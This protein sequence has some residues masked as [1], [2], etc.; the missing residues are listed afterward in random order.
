L[1]TLG[2]DAKLP[3]RGLTSENIQARCRGVLL[4]ALSNQSGVLLL[5]CTNKSE[6]AMGYGTLY[7]DLTGGFAVLK[8]VSKTRV[9]E[10]ANFRNVDDVFPYELLTRSPTAELAENQKDEDILPP[11]SQLDPILE[12]YVEQHKSI[13]DIV[14]AGFSKEIV[15]RIVSSVDKNEFKRRQLAPGPKITPHAFNRER[16][17]PITS[18]FLLP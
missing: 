10:L 18:G 8:D 14:K 13:D 4:M 9:Y 17:F 1:T 11:Y 15:Q 12:L 6:L 5:N 3:P 16:R 2:F 7:G